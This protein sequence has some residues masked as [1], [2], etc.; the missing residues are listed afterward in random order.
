MRYSVIKKLAELTNSKEI[1][2][3][4]H[5]QLYHRL[6]KVPDEEHEQMISEAIALSSIGVSSEEDHKVIAYI[7]QHVRTVAEDITG[8]KLSQA[9]LAKVSRAVFER[10]GDNSIDTIYGFYTAVESGLNE[11][12]LRK[13]SYPN[14]DYG[15]SPQRPHNLERWMSSMREIYFKVHKGLPF[16]KAL[17][18]VTSDWDK[19]EKNDFE[20]WLSYYQQGTHNKYKTA[21]YYQEGGEGPPLIP[22][23]HLQ[24]KLPGG[25]APGMPNMDMYESTKKVDKKMED[26]LLL[27]EE[28][29]RKDE[30]AA[31]KQ[32]LRNKIL[33]RLNAAERLVSNPKSQLDLND[34]LDMGVDKWLETLHSLKRVIQTAPL[35]SAA[36]PI[37]FDLIVR[38]GNQLSQAGYPKA[39][40]FLTK[41]AQ[42]E[43]VSLEDAATE[44]D[45]EGEEAAPA[46]PAPPPSDPAAAMPPLEE[47]E[48]ED[49]AMED[50]VRKMNNEPT[51]DLEIED[52]TI[53][54]EA[55]ALPE[56]IEAPTP[57]LDEPAAIEV[58]DEPPPPPESELSSELKNVSMSSLIRR[59]EAIADIL[60]K[61]ELPREYA[62]ADL[63]MSE[64]GVG[65]FFPTHAEAHRSALESN[66]YQL[67]RVEDILS[68]LRGAM[69][70]SNPIE[71]ST[72]PED[73]AGANETLEQ[74]RENLTKT[75]EAE[76]MRQEKRKAD[77][78]AKEMEEL[79][80]Q[81][82]TQELQAPVEVEQAPPARVTR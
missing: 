18:N 24:G 8:L 4:F 9:A 74:V 28:R 80:Q 73:T 77:R 42:N 43:Q 76:R 10:R 70:V 39:G 35:K 27:L 45:M 16:K 25:K 60:R 40:T 34:C 54:V 41:L 44:I 50:F 29:K 30:E 20:K 26:E 36:S 32:D 75:E 14:H 5:D 1:N 31:R 11:L 67:S 52:G 6:D 78:Q 68:R 63:E 58:V 19:M 81:Q 66:S 3:Y 62:L 47:E 49:A 72:T 12:G 7:R 46:A 71:L 82:A 59:F 38:H 56:A 15:I 13:R 55:Q 51:D 22:M 2:D 61:R 21:Q 69:Q 65:S 23:S 79:E 37:L 48:S 53:T 33:S 17:D 64:L 57:N